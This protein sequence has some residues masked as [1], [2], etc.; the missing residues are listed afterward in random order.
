MPRGS[1]DHGIL[2]GV[3]KGDYIQEDG[4]LESILFTELR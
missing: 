3:V 1:D 4:S 2:A